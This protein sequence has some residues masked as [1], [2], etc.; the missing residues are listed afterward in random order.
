MRF[1]VRGGKPLRGEIKLAGSK[2]GATNLMVATLLTDELCTLHNF[3]SIGDTAI[4]AELCR[5]I[6][7][8]IT[9]RGGMAT[10]H[11]PSIRQ[12]KVAELSR[13][14]RIP[15]LAMGPL[16]SRAGEAEVPI[17]G[18][19]KIG[20]RPVDFHLE[21]LRALG[22]T[23]EITEKSYVARAP[24]GLRGAVIQLPFPSVGATE[25]SILA[26]VL[27]KG[28]TEIRNAA[29]EPEIMSMMK[30]LQN[31][32]AIVELGANRDIYIEGVS[33]LRGAAHEIIPDRNEAVSFA[34]LALATRGEI[35]VR[36]ALQDHLITFLNV[37]R[38]MGAE[39]NVVSGGIVFS[40]PSL[41][42]AISVET[43]PHPGFMTDWQ[44]PLAVLLTQAQGKSTIHETIYEDRFG[45]AEDLRALG[46]R[47]EVSN[48]CAEG[49][50]CHF[51][52]K[53]CNHSAT[54]E[55]PVEL[56]SDG[57]EFRVR[58]LRSGMI[59]VSAA[60]VSKGETKIEGVEEIDRGYERIDERLRKLGA[61]IRREA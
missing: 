38:R 28:K 4:T 31:M 18:G 8:E 59:N 37:V 44:Q 46:A 61:D 32:G 5:K 34:C 16:L 42:R 30:M 50:A 6:G 9:V 24:Q 53:A 56:K 10:V 26:A 3:P 43:A 17:L 21:A 45:Y 41:L 11:T 29:L 39:Y 60:L 1:V 58:D 23:V 55:G 14:N 52:G 7:S 13:R 2:N 54:I 25:T 36:G 48:G 40:R 27:A 20:P 49:H 22:A 51:S 35:L 57:K 33:K 47:I 15:I 12:S 19:D